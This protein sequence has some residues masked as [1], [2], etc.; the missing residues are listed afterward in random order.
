MHVHVLYP[1][2]ERCPRSGAAASPQMTNA[3]TGLLF[4]ALQWITYRLKCRSWH[5]P[6]LACDAAE[7]AR[8]NI[9]LYDLI[10]CDHHNM[11]VPAANYISMKPDCVYLITQV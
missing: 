2:P 8:C 4:R 5:P 11:Y 9:R 6:A 1:M 10:C 7:S 3:P